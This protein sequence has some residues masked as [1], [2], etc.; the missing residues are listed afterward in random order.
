MEVT[1]AWARLAI[2]AAIFALLTVTASAQDAP[3]Y[4]S[5]G[6]GGPLYIG[7]N[8]QTGG[9]YSPP[10]YDSNSHSREHY[11]ERNVYQAPKKRSRPEPEKT[12]TAKSAPTDDDAD[13]V[14]DKAEN[15]NS[16]I[17]QGSSIAKADSDTKS[18]TA[19]DEQNEN[20]T[21]TRASLDKDASGAKTTDAPKPAA[22]TQNVGCKKYFPAVGM[23]LSVPCE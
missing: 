15:E 23:T 19:K 7:P 10:N 2:T 11:K 13:K 14:K 17:A 5:R 1:M 4:E 6:Y 12:H 22:T 3:S 21:I 9:K 20:S 16:G 8:F 18:D